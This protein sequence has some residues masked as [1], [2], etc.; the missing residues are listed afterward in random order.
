M[1]NT[2]EQELKMYATTEHVIMNTATTWEEGYKK[3]ARFE[4]RLV[5]K[6]LLTPEEMEL[7]YYMY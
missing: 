7:L 1:M 2:R 5:D 3:V 6:G 4:K